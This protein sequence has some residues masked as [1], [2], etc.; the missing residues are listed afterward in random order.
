MEGLYL[1]LFGLDDESMPVNP[2]EKHVISLLL[3]F[4]VTVAIIGVI[5]PVVG[6]M[7]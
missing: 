3:T 7:E 5:L 2:H 1:I 6:F 4:I